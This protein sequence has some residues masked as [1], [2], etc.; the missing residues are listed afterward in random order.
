MT[1]REEDAT[2]Q[3]KLRMKEKLR[4]RLEDASIWNDTSIT[5]E[6]IDRLNQSFEKDDRVTHALGNQT[7]EQIAKRV[8]SGLRQ[9]AAKLADDEANRTDYD[10]TRQFLA[11]LIGLAQGLSGVRAESLLNKVKNDDAWRDAATF[12][13]AR[14]RKVSELEAGV[15]VT[16]PENEAARL[17]AANYKPKTLSEIME[18]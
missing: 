14:Q 1:E 13:V 12:V 16:D 15:L 10:E 2:I 6:I 17:E 11:V 8:L 7:A 18:R 9:A 4:R 3:F 5:A